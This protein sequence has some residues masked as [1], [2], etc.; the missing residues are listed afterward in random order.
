MEGVFANGTTIT[1]NKG[2]HD[3]KGVFLNATV[4]NIH[5]EDADIT[6]FYAGSSSFTGESGSTKLLVHSASHIN[7]DLGDGNNEVSLG[8]QDDNATYGFLGE[9]VRFGGTRFYSSVDEYTLDS[10]GGI[11]HGVL[12]GAS[13]DVTRGTTT[14]DIN[15]GFER[16]VTHHNATNLRDI[17]NQD[18]IV[19]IDNNRTK[20]TK[21]AQP[22]KQ[23]QTTKIEKNKDS[24]NDT[25]PRYMPI[26]NNPHMGGNFDLVNAVEVKSQAGIKHYQQEHSQQLSYGRTLCLFTTRYAWE[27]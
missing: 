25:S 27:V 13:V 21:Q 24:Q 9:M 2:E 18:E 22:T 8:A 16:E 17:E 12:V 23:S 1:L 19:Q 5:A 14:L 11:R 10:H 3:I 7:V 20:A 15:T 26:Y 4:N 6:A